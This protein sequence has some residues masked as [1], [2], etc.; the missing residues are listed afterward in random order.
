MSRDF[1]K[2]LA[3][4]CR[5]TSV[6]HGSPI[7]ES[8]NVYSVLFTTHLYIIDRHFKHIE[9]RLELFIFLYQEFHNDSKNISFNI[10]FC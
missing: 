7:T 5:N 6:R 10:Y 3:G 1:L 4:L 8:H 9:P 2:I